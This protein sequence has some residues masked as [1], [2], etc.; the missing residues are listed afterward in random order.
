[1][2]PIEQPSSQ[3]P[4]A[5]GT[6]AGRPAPEERLNLD[7][8]G[9]T[10]ELLV[11]DIVGALAVLLTDGTEYFV[12]F[13]R[14]GH[15]HH[16]PD[17]PHNRARLSAIVAIRYLPPAGAVN[18]NLASFLKNSIP[19]GVKAATLVKDAENNYW[20]VVSIGGE[21]EAF[22]ANDANAELLALNDFVPTVKA[23]PRKDSKLGL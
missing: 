23:G 9:D 2:D 1:M 3:E 13:T 4:N 22:D 20:Y 11:G 18:A 12:I 14:S 17:N 6:E 7:P 16:A 15:Q 21:T 8:A 19:N 10:G 5:E